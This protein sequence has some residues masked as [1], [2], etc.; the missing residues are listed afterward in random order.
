MWVESDAGKAG[1]GSREATTRVLVGV[2][3]SALGETRVGLV[4]SG[5]RLQVRVWAEHAE[6]LKAREEAIR[7]DL[8]D[9][10]PGLDFQVLPLGEPGEAV[11]S[12]RALANGTGFQALG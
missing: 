2:Q 7:S 6:V 8:A 3:F 10:G 4:Q 5:T 9:L 1:G 11:P 12:L